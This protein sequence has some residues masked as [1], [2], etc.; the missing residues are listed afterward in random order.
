[1]NQIASSSESLRAGTLLNVLSSRVVRALRSI[2]FGRELLQCGLLK[3][4]RNG[5]NTYVWSDNWI[6]DGA[7]RRLINKKHNI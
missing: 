5:Y 2:L 1:M 3:L 7:P 6:L 4:V